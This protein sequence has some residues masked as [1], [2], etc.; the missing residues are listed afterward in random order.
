MTKTLN[1]T[2]AFWSL[3]FLAA[4]VLTGLAGLVAWQAPAMAQ[5]VWLACQTAVEAVQGFLPAAG[6]LLPLLLVAAAFLGG[7]WS[8]TSQVWHTHWLVRTLAAR[9][10][11][12]SQ[13]LAD[14]GRAL[15]LDGRLVL[16]E[17]NAPYTFT[18]G[19]AAPRVWLSTGLLGLLDEAELAAVLRHERHHIARRDPLRILITRTLART[20][21][22]V[23]LARELCDSYLVAKE[24]D[25]DAATGADEPLAGALLKLLRQGASLPERA[26]LAAIG[27]VDATGARIERLLHRE[28]QGRPR[29]GLRRLALSLL[30]GLMIFSISY[31]SVGRA[32][33]PVQGG[34]CGYS[35]WVD[36]VPPAPDYTPIDAVAP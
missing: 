1:A 19:L 16:V 28:E 6:L 15:G 8:L 18:Q 17:D 14:L 4:I 31:T 13:E 23:P 21:F 27:P 9:R 22:F 10:R 26:S 33:A 36:T 25:A 29:I 24:V 11:P 12:P 35:T 2:Q 30:L 7:A 20:L 32:A 34:E 3:V 5:G